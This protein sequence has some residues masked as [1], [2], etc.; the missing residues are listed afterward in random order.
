MCVSSVESKTM[1]LDV[2]DLYLDIRV[3]MPGFN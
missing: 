1:V 2:L 3:Y